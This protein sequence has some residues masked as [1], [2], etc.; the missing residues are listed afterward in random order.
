MK[1]ASTMPK[2]APHRASVVVP[3][4]DDAD[5]ANVIGDDY[6]ADT[7]LN[8]IKMMSG[9]G[10]LFPALIGMVKAVIDEPDNAAKRR[11]VMILRAASV[12]NS[13][14]EWQ[15]N[16]RMAHNAGLLPAEIKAIAGDSPLDSLDGD[17]QRLIAA[18]DELLTSG[19]L[20]DDT[21]GTAPSSVDS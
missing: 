15:V 16:E 12:L 21:L 20:T 7:T 8:V 10:E 13:P 6:D 3:L 4:P 14:Y 17:C 11:L 18:T 5:V 9:T 2:P 19:T 1:E